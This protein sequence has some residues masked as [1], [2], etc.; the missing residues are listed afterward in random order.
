MIA[1][2][3]GQ[4]GHIERQGTD[5]ALIQ[6]V[7]RHFH[8]HG[9][10]TG[11]LQVSQHG[12]YGNRVRGGM[13]T[14]LQCAI[15]A[16]AQGANNAAMLPQQ[17]QRLRNQLGNAGF[18]VGTGNAHQ[19]HVMARVTIKTPGDRR[20]LRRQPLDRDQR[21]GGDRQYVRAFYFIGHG[22]CATLQGVSDMFTTIELATRYREEQIPGSHIAAVE[23]QLTDQQIVTCV[24][25]NLVQAQ[26]H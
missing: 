15:K 18:A 20:Q 22:C 16:R 3:V 21:Y 23:G 12:L 13:A 9:L 2:Q 10:G 7:G 11:F 6:P 19:V 17:V 5:P 14:A 4:H 1:R 24:R 8:R 25:E 26:G